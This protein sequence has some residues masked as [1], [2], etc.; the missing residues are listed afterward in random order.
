MYCDRWRDKTANEHRLFFGPFVGLA[1]WLLGRLGICGRE[2]FN[3]AEL[4]SKASPG[5]F[6]RPI[7]I[8]SAA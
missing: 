8:G 1:S 2:S 5:H 7:L 4:H 3:Y 6:I